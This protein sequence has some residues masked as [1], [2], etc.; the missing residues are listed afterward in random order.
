MKAF[1]L[2]RDVLLLSIVCSVAILAGGW[3]VLTAS[4]G[5]DWPWADFKPWG[6]AAASPWLL[7]FAV[8]LWL[9]WR[10]LWAGLEDLAGAD[11]DG[12]GGRG[13]AQSQAVDSDVRLIPVKGAV[14]VDGVDQRDL[15]EFVDGLAVRGVGGRAWVGQKLASGRV[16]DWPYH[17]KLCA[18]LEKAGIVQ[19]RGSRKAGYL[20]TSDAAE[21]R[22]ALRLP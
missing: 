8:L 9:V 11:L 13:A 6:L 3:L 18:I 15:G 20:V 16:V 12:I 2:V 22:Q 7:A 4:R 10:R 14:M 5:F 17:A 1:T 19:G 21:I